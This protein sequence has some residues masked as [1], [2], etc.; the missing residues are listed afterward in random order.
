MDWN[1]VRLK[2]CV[3]HICMLCKIDSE[4]RFNVIRTMLL[5]L[6]NHAYSWII[7]DCTYT[8][9]YSWGKL[10]S[11]SKLVLSN[12]FLASFT[13]HK[14]M[15]KILKRSKNRQFFKV[16][17]I[18]RIDGS[19]I[20]EIS[21]SW[22]SQRSKNGSSLILEYSKNRSWRFFQNTKVPHKIALNLK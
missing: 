1:L 18:I 7:R 8:H 2:T 16:F 15:D 17:E 14:W 11:S 10:W 9:I 4:W 22:E 12:E 21:V 5:A 20:L 6:V 13:S 3:R 19:L